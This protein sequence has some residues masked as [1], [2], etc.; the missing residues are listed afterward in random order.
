MKME[1]PSEAIS[2]SM[3]QGYVAAVDEEAKRYG[4]NRS[5]FIRVLFDAYYTVAA[6]MIL[7]GER[8]DRKNSK[9]SLPDYFPEVLPHKKQ[10]ADAWLKD[11]LKIV[12]RITREAEQRKKETGSVDQPAVDVSWRPEED[13]STDN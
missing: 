13:E 4:F 6:R 10:E 1:V 7:L 11:Y 8:E 2:I 12:I 5:E 9:T 3:P